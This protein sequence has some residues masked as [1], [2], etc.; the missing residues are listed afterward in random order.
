MFVSEFSLNNFRSYPQLNLD[1]QPG[2]NI[3]I[4][5]NGQGKTNVV[6][7]LEYLAN[8]KSHR[9]A[10]DDPLIN[11]TANQA[12]VRANIQAGITDSRKRLA[13][14]IINKGKAN[15]ASINRNKCRPR[16]LIGILKTVVF[17]PED[18]RII[19]GDPGDRR[20]FI[21]EM[22]ILRW[23]RLAGV[24][25]DFEK[26]LKQRNALLKKAQEPDFS[27]ALLQVWDEALCRYGAEIMAARIQTLADMANYVTDIYREIAPSN[28]FTQAIYTSSVDLT[29]T[30]VAGLE[31]A[32]L[33]RIAL[34]RDVELIRGVTLVGPQRDDIE[35]ILGDF[36]AKG[37][38][39]HGESWSLALAL[40]LGAYELVKAENI[41]PILIL[42]D[43]FAE[44]DETRRQHL[45]KW[46]N[47]AEQVFI[48]AAVADD[49]PQFLASHRYLVRT[50]EVTK[51]NDCDIRG[52]IEVQY[53]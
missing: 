32:M 47:T 33:A 37:Y 17:S 51:E 6:E 50:G 36:P 10:K 34:R 2:V 13:E 41:E 53:E 14:I 35:I 49:I 28:N 44:L 29:D 21:D 43:V 19:K 46:I 1:F 25:S 12:I 11:I 23:P 22:I 18:L 40:R 24:K 38:A 15:Q 20:R 31:K 52:A 26:V 7:A 30:S 39:S 3:L 45:A 27:P 16:D 4:G 9:V 8:L 48:T 5:A 42:D